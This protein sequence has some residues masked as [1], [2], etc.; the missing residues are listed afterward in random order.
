[1]LQGPPPNLG[2][3]SLAP[4]QMAPASPPPPGR[5]G[6]LTTAGMPIGSQLAPQMPPQILALLHSLMAK[7][8]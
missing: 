5:L 4:P 8:K 1:M 6:G 7:R 2:A 3:A